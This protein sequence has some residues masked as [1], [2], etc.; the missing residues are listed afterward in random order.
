MLSSLSNSSIQTSFN[1]YSILD[2]DDVNDVNDANIENK[3]E[4][5]AEEKENNFIDNRTEAKHNITI[6]DEY[7]SSFSSKIVYDEKNRCGRQSV[8]IHMRT[9]TLFFKFDVKSRNQMMRSHM[10]FRDAHDIL[11]STYMYR[12]FFSMVANVINNTPESEIKDLCVLCP[13][14]A[15]RDTQLGVTGK[16]VNG[17]PVYS[18]FKELFEE[19]GIFVNFDN[20]D[21]YNRC[22]DDSNRMIN[23][24]AVNISKCDSSGEKVRAATVD[25]E[26]M[27]TKSS[28]DNYKNKIQILVYGSYVDAKRLLRSINHRTKAF[29][30]KNIIGV[31]LIS[32]RDVHHLIQDPKMLIFMRDGY[33]NSLR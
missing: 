12:G 19:I 16:V 7:T 3:T 14:Y 9:N 29:D 6:L 32:L 15:V 17:D 10:V 11:F 21:L 1:Q 25:D 33:P 13:Y 4:E 31:R 22:Y 26:R 23:N 5:K 30:N 28:K 27:L 24:Y 8:L 18:S 2:A 20:I